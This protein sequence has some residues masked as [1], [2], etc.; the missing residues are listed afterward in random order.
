ML[1][2][3]QASIS[4]RM[5][6]K[7]PFTLADL[8]RLAEHLGVPVARLLEPPELLVDDDEAPTDESETPCPPR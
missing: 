6:G 2:L 7:T 4:D 5:T 3:S 1:G 8:D